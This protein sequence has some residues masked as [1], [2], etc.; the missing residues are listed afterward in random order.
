MTSAPNQITF[1]EWLPLLE[2][3]DSTVEAGLDAKR[4]EKAE[5]SKEFINF[6]YVY[7]IGGDGTLLR[8]LRILYTRCLP[9]CLPKI[10]TFS[11]GS[12]SYLC[13]FDMSEYKKILDATALSRP[14]MRSV[15]IDYRTRL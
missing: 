4:P 3:D 15:Q 2:E 13:N 12:M 1:H 9:P 7:C 11:M 6:D 14:D 10:V 5:F 8:L